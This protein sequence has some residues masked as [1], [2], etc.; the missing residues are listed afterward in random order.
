MLPP[1]ILLYSVLRLL[2]AM[3]MC[4][5]FLSISMH[6]CNFLFWICIS[7][8]VI[9]WCDHHHPE[10]SMHTSV[11]PMTSPTFT[12]GSSF[13]HRRAHWTSEQN[14]ETIVPRSM[15]LFEYLQTSLSAPSGSVT[16]FGPPNKCVLQNLF[17][18]IKYVPQVGPYIMTNM[19]EPLW[20]HKI[21]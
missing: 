4:V 8:H 12:W 7:M 14:C 20:N 5:S 17:R 3:Y 10:Q 18:T 19:H 2:R 1:Y 11:V 15:F 16:K 21:I 9:S 13:L 6:A